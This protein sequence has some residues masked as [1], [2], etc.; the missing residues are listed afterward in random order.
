MISWSAIAVVVWAGVWALA[1][2]ALRG[3]EERAEMRMNRKI[4]MVLSRVHRLEARTDTLA[5]EN[6]LLKEGGPY[7]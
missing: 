5:R 4:D 1:R 7:R 6:E 3:I 2:V